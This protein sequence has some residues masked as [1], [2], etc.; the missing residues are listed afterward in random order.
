MFGPTSSNQ[1]LISSGNQTLDKFLGGGL[2]NSTLNIFERQGP[3]SRLLDVVISKSFAATT[4]SS[5]NNLLVVNLNPTQ[6]IDHRKVISGLPTPRQVNTEILYKDIKGKSQLSK[7][8]I[9]WRYSSKSSSPS[10]INLKSNQVDFGLS[11][12]SDH[13]DTDLG[14]LKVIN[15]PVPEDFHLHTLLQDLENS[16]AELKKGCD[17]LNVIVKGLYH[18]FSPLINRPTEQLRFLYCLRHISRML[19]KGAIILIYDTD[20]VSD[21]ANMKYQIYNIADC[22]VSTFS[23]ETD[24]NK[25]SGYK[26][27]DGTLDYV[28]VPKINTF[29]LHFQQELSDWGY[30]F[31]NNHRYFVV[32]EL[33]LPPCHDDEQESSNKQRKQNATDVT[34]I[35]H[36]RKPMERVGP[37]EDFREVAGEV[38]ARQL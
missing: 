1:N 34:H 25:L 33:S 3:S 23:F 32:D 14:I 7:I 15:V 35:E 18:P 36:L 11:L 28:K 30:R 9:A 20:M 17:S 6:E 5:K 22:V 26:N 24:Q 16:I 8:K 29:G 13:K 21:Y 38:L 37:L 12:A 27:I 2:L 19:T 31:T 4:L 10:D